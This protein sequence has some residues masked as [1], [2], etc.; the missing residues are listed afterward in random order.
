MKTITGN[1]LLS[2]VN[3]ADK[4]KVEEV[5]QDLKNSKVRKISFER[6]TN[7]SGNFLFS[8]KYRKGGLIGNSEL[9]QSEAGMENGIKNLIRRINSLSEEN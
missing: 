4:A 2:S 8:L 7:H 5:V 3:Y 9:Y 1:T 6:K